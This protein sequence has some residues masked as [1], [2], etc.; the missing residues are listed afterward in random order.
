[1]IE[2]EGFMP[3]NVSGSYPE[4]SYLNEIKKKTGTQEFSWT[5]DGVMV[6]DGTSQFG[7]IKNAT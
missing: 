3:I 7:V 4:E 6:S 1:M 2:N 5:P